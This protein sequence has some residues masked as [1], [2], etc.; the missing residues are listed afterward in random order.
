MQ[1]ERYIFFV[2]VRF[3][4]KLHPPT[5]THQTFIRVLLPL[6]MRAPSPQHPKSTSFI[7]SREL[8]PSSWKVFREAG[9]SIAFGTV[10]WIRSGI[11]IGVLPECTAAPACCFSTSHSY[12][13]LPG[14]PLRL[15][16]SATLPPAHW[17]AILRC[18]S[19]NHESNGN[20]SR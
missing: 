5:K 7:S 20:P 17:N 1:T 8:D 10:M 16:P 14:A 11:G 18:A 6:P 15:K 19:K 2:A 12:L 3:H 13:A 4:W 9:N